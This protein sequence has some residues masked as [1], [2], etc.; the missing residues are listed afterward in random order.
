[1]AP[2]PIGGVTAEIL[3]D[4]SSPGT[5]NAWS[6]QECGATSEG[7]MSPVAY[8]LAPVNILP[9]P[10]VRP[11][12]DTA[13]NGEGMVPSDNV[14]GELGTRFLARNICAE[15]GRFAPPNKCKL[16]PAETG[17]ACNQV[18]SD[19]EGSF[20]TDIPPSTLKVNPF[21]PDVAL[22]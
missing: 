7:A 4:G 10:R 1:M 5:E 20:Q 2:S 3:S 9:L 8:T 12:A 13:P 17:S 16:P 6:E 15:A 18:I 21:E 14:P 19:A 11:N 22:M